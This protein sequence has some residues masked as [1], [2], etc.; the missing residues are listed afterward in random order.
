[1]TSILPFSLL[2]WTWLAV[3]AASPAWADDPLAKPSNASAREHLQQGNRLY[4]LREFEK[5]IDDYKA[6]VLIE[7]APVF[8]YNLGQCYRQLGRYEDA[9]WHYQRFLDRAKPTGAIAITVQGFVTD[10]KA[11]LEKRAMTKPPTEPAQTSPPIDVQRPSPHIAPVLVVREVEPWYA[12]K[13]GWMLTGSGVVAG[14][15]SGYLLLDANDLDTQANTEDRQDVRAQLRDR[16]STRRWAGAISGI[17]AAGL[18]TLG[19]VKLAIT[20]SPSSQPI[21]VSITGS[22]FAV[23]GRF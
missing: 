22:G 12:D 18:L 13:V 10:M 3:A 5:A 16:A 7:D 8:A 6:G 23:A 9:I 11:E 20:T 15:V 4:R 17:G 14:L 19:I 21:A 2:C 1:M